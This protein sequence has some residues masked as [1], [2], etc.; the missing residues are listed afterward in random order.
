MYA[1]TA[2]GLPITPATGG[3]GNTVTIPGM[4]GQMKNKFGY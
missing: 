1:N 2:A 4:L 3:T